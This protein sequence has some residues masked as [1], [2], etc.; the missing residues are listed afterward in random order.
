MRQVLQLH[1]DGQCAPVARLEAD[2]A[3]GPAGTL[4]LRYIVSGEVT[5]LHLPAPAARVRADELWRTTCFEA[6]VQEAGSGAYLEINLAP[7]GQWAVYAFTGYRQG[8]RAVDEAPAPALDSERTGERY[9]LVATLDL[10]ATGL[11]PGEPWRLALS[12]VI[13]EA[14]GAKSYWALA[15]PPGKPDFHHPQSFVLDLPAPEVP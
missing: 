6:F 5:A 2:V 1:P 9:E 11:R 8:M 15:H 7:A 14:G 13:E 3:R 12:A 4:R 10:A